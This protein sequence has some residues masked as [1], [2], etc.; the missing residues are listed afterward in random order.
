MKIRAD[1]NR[2]RFTLMAAGLL[3]V[4]AALHINASVVPADVSIDIFW[5]KFKAA[6]IKGDKEAVSTMCQFPITMPYRVPSIRTKAQFLRRYRAL[7]KDQADAA[8][9][10]AEAKPEVDPSTKNAFTIP[11][12]DYGG[13]ENILY[14]FVRKRGVWKLSYLDNVAE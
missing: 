10:F 11:C 9:C 5:A 12:K 7:F 13:A 3:I 1:K 4:I 2:R 6:V 14:G 8:K